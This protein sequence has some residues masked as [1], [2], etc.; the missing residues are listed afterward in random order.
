MTLIA[1]QYLCQFYPDYQ[2]AESVAEIEINKGLFIS[3]AKSKLKDGWKA[4]FDKQEKES[5]LPKL[6]A[7]QKLFCQKG[8]VVEK[9]TQPPAHFTDATLLGCD[10]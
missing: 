5:F 3:K 4:L 1:R 10:E 8:E 6:K 9:N 2:Y 7:G